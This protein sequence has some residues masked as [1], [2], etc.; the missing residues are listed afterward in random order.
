MLRIRVLL[1]MRMYG[2]HLY[3]ADIPGSPSRKL[4]FRCIPSY[5]S[6]KDATLGS[7]KS[8]LGINSPASAQLPFILSPE[9]SDL[10]RLSHLLLLLLLLIRALAEGYRVRFPDFREKK[11]D[12]RLST[13]IRQTWVPFFHFFQA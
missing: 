10:P 2:L 6:V 12:S 11:K 5:P 7:A 8:N 4:V 3:S 9:S 1:R 13:N